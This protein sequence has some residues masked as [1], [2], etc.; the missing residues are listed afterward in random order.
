[1]RRGKIRALCC[2]ALLGLLLEAAVITG[3]PPRYD[4]PPNP[5][6]RTGRPLAEPPLRAY[7]PSSYYDPYTQGIVALPQK[8]GD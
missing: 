2:L 6:Q 3:N 4:L 1:M 7:P 5:P 8:G